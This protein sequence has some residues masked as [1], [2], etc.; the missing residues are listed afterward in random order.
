MRYKIEISKDLDIS[1]QDEGP[2]RS[3]LLE[4]YGDDFEQVWDNAFVYELDQDG[5][6]LNLYHVLEAPKNVFEKAEQILKKT[7]NQ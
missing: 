1:Y 7:L 6:E 3:Y 2:W 5:G 4:A